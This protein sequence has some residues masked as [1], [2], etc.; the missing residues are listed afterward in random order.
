MNIFDVPLTPLPN[1]TIKVEINIDNEKKAFYLSFSYKEICGY[2]VM[3][4][5]DSFKNKQLS[6]VPLLTGGGILEAGNLLKQFGYKQLGSALIL[7]AKK[8]DNDIPN[9]KDLG[10]SFEL[11]WGDTDTSDLYNYIEAK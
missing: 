8:T 1:Q 10:I 7:E 9:E 11:Y 6:N 4:V 5:L 2:W 3:D